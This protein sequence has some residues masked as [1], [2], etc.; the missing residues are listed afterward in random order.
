MAVTLG[1]LE[2]LANLHQLL[3]GSEVCK[4]DI[5]LGTLHIHVHPDLPLVFREGHTG[6]DGIIKEVADDTAKIQL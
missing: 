5:E 3:C 6:L 2:Q 4:G 1:G